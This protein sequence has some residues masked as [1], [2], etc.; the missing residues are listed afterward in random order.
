HPPLRGKSY[1]VVRNARQSSQVRGSWVIELE[2]GKRMCIPFGS[3]ELVE[4]RDGLQAPPKG[5]NM[6]RTAAPASPEAAPDA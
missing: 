4:A 2:N 5:D 3:G 1:P 6:G